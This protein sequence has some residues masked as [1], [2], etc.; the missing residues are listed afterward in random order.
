MFD[1][2]PPTVDFWFPVLLFLFAGIHRTISGMTH[3]CLPGYRTGILGWR[4]FT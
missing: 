1:S 4:F 3:I 2:K